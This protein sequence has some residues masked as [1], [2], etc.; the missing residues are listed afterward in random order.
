MKCLYCQ[1]QMSQGLAPFQVDRRA[2]HL[3]LDRVP[4]WVCSQCGEVYFDESA[5]RAVQDLI[6]SVEQQAGKLALT[7]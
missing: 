3:R 1:G 4:A 6:E 2:V 5:V 7:A